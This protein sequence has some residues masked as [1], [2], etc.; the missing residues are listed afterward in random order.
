MEDIL[1]G[2]AGRP[3]NCSPVVACEER[4]DAVDE[5]G[6]DLGELA[7]YR[8]NRIRHTQYGRIS[9]NIRCSTP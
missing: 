9:A 6:T 2:C 3:R 4:W 5:G 8:V 7:D 1:G